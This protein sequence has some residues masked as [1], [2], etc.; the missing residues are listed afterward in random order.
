MSFAPDFGHSTSQDAG[1]AAYSRCHS[2][3]RWVR[4]CLCSSIRV[5][6]A[7]QGDRKGAE[8]GFSA[9]LYSSPSQGPGRYR[10]VLARK[11][12]ATFNRV[13]ADPRRVDRGQRATS[14]GGEPTSPN[15]S[16]ID[17]R[18]L[19]PET[20]SKPVTETGPRRN[21]ERRTFST[22]YDR[23]DGQP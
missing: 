14:G 16:N 12:K 20:S 19:L 3:A 18:G 17:Q 9:P 13:A 8:R 22:D 23:R 1:Q 15:R 11:Q 2:V 7:L 4:R 10:W 6:D 5:P 21:I